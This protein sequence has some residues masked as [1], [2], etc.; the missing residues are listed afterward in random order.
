MN[1][2]HYI[3]NKAQSFEEYENITIDGIILRGN[4]ETTYT[5]GDQD[6]FVLSINCPYASEIM[7]DKLFALV[8]GKTY[9]GYRAGNA[10]LDPMA[11]L[12]DGVTVAGLYS[13]LAY[14]QVTFGP[15]HT[16]EISAPAES[17]LNHEYQYVGQTQREI[18]KNEEESKK[19][20]EDAKKELE[21]YSDQAAKD[22]AQDAVNSQTD[23]DILAKLTDNGRRKG[24]FIQ[25]DELYVS[26]NAI[27]TG[28]LN[29][30]RVAI[31]GTYGSI[32]QGKGETIVNGEMV[33]TDGIVIYGPLG[34]K[35]PYLIVTT[36]GVRIESADGAANLF[37]AGTHVT[38]KGESLRVENTISM[39]TADADI[40]YRV[41]SM[42]LDNPSKFVVGNSNLNLQFTAKER[43]RLQ[44][45][46]VLM[47]GAVAL[48]DGEPFNSGST[49]W[50]DNHSLYIIM[51]APN[52]STT[53]LVV[54]SAAITSTRESYL[55][56]DED[57]YRSFYLERSGNLITLTIRSGQGNI[58]GI[59]G[60][61]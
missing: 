21:D 3:G 37:V 38:T 44:A 17:G 46:E 1:G 6:G 31:A 29:A 12:G 25:D 11:E 57:S 4:G 20:L 43:I 33:P 48:L 2:K 10:I 39:R 52:S 49:S 23:E 34:D 15:D 42:V 7:A 45:P 53:S 54:P 59:Y 27:L 28:I 32:V 9:K 16:S 30:E 18:D 13:V 55:L 24:I 60:L 51:G 61:L 26:A 40:Y 22:A 35:G 5:R 36:D 8:N 41:L 47:D 19:D 56:S 58:T 50:E 14:R